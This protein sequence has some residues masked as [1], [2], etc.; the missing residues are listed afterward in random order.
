MS[1]SI[2]D[3]E[4]FYTVGFLQSSGFDDWQHFDQQNKQVLRHCEDA[5]IGIKQYLPHHRTREDWARHFGTKWSTFCE[6]KTRFDPKLILSPGQMIFSYGY[7][8]RQ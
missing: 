8:D 4:V 7:R 6:R 1:A 2:P 3:E 5:G